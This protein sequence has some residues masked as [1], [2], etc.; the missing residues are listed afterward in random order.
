VAILTEESI[1]R[2]RE[3]RDLWKECQ[4][5]VIGIVKGEVIASWTWPLIPF[6]G[7]SGE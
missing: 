4:S 1:L 5:I 6:V 2:E 7:A 3:R